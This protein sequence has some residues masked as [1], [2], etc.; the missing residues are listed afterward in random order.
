M[1][2]YHFYQFNKFEASQFRLR[3][4]KISRPLFVNN[5]DTLTNLHNSS[6]QN[7]NNNSQYQ[8]N[9]KQSS[10]NII[11]NF[12]NDNLQSNSESDSDN[13]YN[14]SWDNIQYENNTNLESQN[15]NESIFTNTDNSDNSSNNS[16]NLSEIFDNINFDFL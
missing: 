1:L 10:F 14:S 16:D 5:E 9:T 3:A 7:D 13:W 12:T 15:N 8:Q 6:L 11:E 4:S 2:R